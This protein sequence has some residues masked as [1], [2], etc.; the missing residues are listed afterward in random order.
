MQPSTSITRLLVIG[1]GAMGSQ[2]ALTAALAGYTTV[3]QD[4]ALS[5]LDGILR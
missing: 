3:V 4:I 5:R 2:I 1:A